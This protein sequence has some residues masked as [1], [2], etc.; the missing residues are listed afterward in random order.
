MKKEE[1]K[2]PPV[3][4]EW[5]HHDD[6]FAHIFQLKGDI[7]REQPGRKTLK[8]TEDHKDYF[9][10][11][12]F[13]VGWPEI[14]KNLSQWRLPVIGAQN[15]VR[16]IQALEQY[17]FTPNLIGYGW[18]GKNPAKQQSFIITQALTST[19]SLE[20][21]CRHWK[22][23][24]PVL[25]LKWALIR[26]V[27]SMAKIIHDNGINHRDFYLCHF[28]LDLTGGQEFLDLHH[29]TLYVIDW[30][31][32]QI[33]KKVPFRWRVKDIA[34]L[35]FSA[36]DI[37]LTQRDLWRFVRI[38]NPSYSP[39]FWHKVVLRAKKLYKELSP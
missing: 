2:L 10:K 35:Y 11:L 34:G 33:R 1:L 5:W 27:A 14:V 21:F 24:P 39:H 7:F 16:A 12:H 29:L 18:R 8:F 28:L 37:G 25:K 4:R 36:M 22:N 15:E 13:G 30:H 9:L 6:M 31:R 23:K 38:Y 32:A 19:T 3:W 26:K 17:H 20:D